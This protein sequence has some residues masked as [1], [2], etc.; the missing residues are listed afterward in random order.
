[1]SLPLPTME[2]GSKVLYVG[3]QNDH[4]EAHAHRC[5]LRKGEIYTVSKFI[6]GMWTDVIQLD[7]IP[8]EHITTLFKKI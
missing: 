4:D 7:G 2:A 6:I 3:N 1:M 8:G 5:N